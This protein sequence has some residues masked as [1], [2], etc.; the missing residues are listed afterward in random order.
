MDFELEEG[1]IRNHAHIE[2]EEDRI[3]NHAHI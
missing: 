2:S 3:R 1:R